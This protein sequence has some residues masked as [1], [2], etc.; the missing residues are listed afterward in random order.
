[1]TDRSETDSKSGKREQ[2]LEEVIADY[3]RACETGDSPDRRQLLDRHPGAANELRQF[4]EQRDRL[5]QMAEPIRGFADDLFRA[6]GPGQQISYVGNYELLQEIARG[7][8]G[9]VF[10]A[11]QT[12]LGRIVAVKMIVAGRMATED[13]V[14]R[15][16]VE[17]QAA[18][19]LQHPHIVSI[20]EVGQH[21]GWH[22]FSMDY[23]EGRDL[24]AFL[25]E[26]LLPAKRAATYV[27]QMA[28][29]IHYA[30]QQGT[31]HRDLKPSNI[32]IDIHDQ[33]RITDFGLAMRV[34][35]ESELTRTGQIV[36]TPSYMPP[37]QAQ[38]RRSLVGPASDVYSLGAILYECLT[39]RAPFRSDSVLKT[40]EQVIHVE[41]ASP[42]ALNA[43]IPRDLETI[44][45]K[46]LQKEPH[47]RYGTAQLLADDLQCYLENRP[48]LARPVSAIERT[49]RWCRR[50]PVVAGLSALSA[51]AIA[52]LIGVLV[53]S[54]GII[55]AALV[56]R[57]TA[58][59][60]QEREQR[61]TQAALTQETEALRQKTDALNLLSIEERKVR[62]AL[63]EKSASLKRER[64]TSYANTLTLARR[65]WLD[66]NLVRTLELL[67]SCHPDLRHWEWHYLRRL[68]EPESLFAAA[69]SGSFSRSPVA[70]DGKTLLVHYAAA[71]AAEELVIANALTGTST[72]ALRSG[73]SLGQFVVSGD[74]RMLL[75]TT[76]K[77]TVQL[78]HVSNIEI[79]DTQSG[80]TVFKSELPNFSIDNRAINNDGTKWAVSGTVWEPN[81]KSSSVHEVRLWNKDAPPV[82]ISTGAGSLVFSPDGQRLLTGHSEGFFL[83]ETS[84]ATK[85][86]ADG[87]N[88]S[89]Y[90]YLL[91]GVTP[92]FR[93]DGTQFASAGGE[94]LTVS[95]TTTGKRIRTYHLNNS[96]VSAV[97]FGDGD[98][99]LAYGTIHG[100]VVLMD[101]QDGKQVV[102][103]RLPQAI[104]QLDFS[105]DG[106]RLVTLDGKGRLQIWDRNASPE[107]DTIS[108]HAKHSFTATFDRSGRLVA[109]VSGR[110]TVR[111]WDIASKDLKHELTPFAGE[112]YDVAFSPEG[113]RLATAG[114]EGIQVWNLETGAVIHRF[115]T[116]N[117]TPMGFGDRVE[118]AHR[119]SWLAG[120]HERGATIWDSDTGMEVRTFGVEKNS[121]WLSS[122]RLTADG[123]R[124]ATCG[125]RG[126]LQL[127]DTATGR[128]L[129]K[130][131]EE[132]SLYTL[133]FSPDERQIYACGLDDDIL[134]VDAK[135]GQELGRLSGH[136]NGA[137]TVAF[138]SDGKRLV[139]AGRDGVV[140]IW[141]AETG[142]EL[143][144]LQ[145][146]SSTCYSAAF[147]LDS[148]RL[149]TT[150][151]GTLRIW[152]AG[153]SP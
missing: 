10:K 144:S 56:D 26:N 73:D 65:E 134:I 109:T 20:H 103:L 68:C 131:E 32:L 59:I 16:Q 47:R 119:G 44:C 38:G 152:D 71:N 50:K 81:A 149:I 34:E 74:G 12:T 40:I 48:I 69:S 105:P 104:R 53:Y 106:T 85:I 37:E 36:G 92:C 76:S 49:W 45:L 75:S 90:P 96:D 100:N 17:A 24:S 58:V 124:L 122:A 41:A 137:N 112:V 107:S 128:E 67:E 136:A 19:S 29:A 15:F 18:A 117:G 11:R 31:L 72:S 138:S 120:G 141:E 3:I 4:F 64:I 108:G 25:R 116:A 14:K 77:T 21:E 52:M 97:A 150:E 60:N 110:Q 13:D 135:T 7:G 148:R 146:N 143:L 9:V 42:R 142:L 54:R 140:K 126:D 115:T 30:H 23:V 101:L 93:R 22:Y 125:H 6:V 127:W 70:S 2:L 83:W 98:R 78:S 121:S 130:V 114:K 95:D 86:A 46:C 63:L 118:F 145:G 84:G 1:M 129:F 94:F 51:F 89:S 5:N 66:G 62:D 99:K 35:G 132:N 39:G 33:V 147:S 27:C 139:S 80:K 43:G 91:S 153:V 87:V 8:M 79:R 102:L 151:I 55:A 123:S 57:S 88:S 82:P 28:E 111:V 61:K 133:T 113:T